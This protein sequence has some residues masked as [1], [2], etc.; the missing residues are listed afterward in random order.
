MR[1]ENIARIGADPQTAIFV[2]EGHP[3][4]WATA[5]AGACGQ[6][7]IKESPQRYRLFNVSNVL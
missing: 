3:Q 4:A 2:L 5:A 6:M 7:G 1:D